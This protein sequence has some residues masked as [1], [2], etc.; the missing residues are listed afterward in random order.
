[1]TGGCH[2][3]SRSDFEL[4]EYLKYL[5]DNKEIHETSRV[6]PLTSTD[7]KDS[8]KNLRYI[9]NINPSITKPYYFKVI[10]NRQPQLYGGRAK[11]KRQQKSLKV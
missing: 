1:V 11:E 7:E 6:S 9:S 10:E 3:K 2:V 4:G 5:I 8:P